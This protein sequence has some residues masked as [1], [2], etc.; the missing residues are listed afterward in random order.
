MLLVTSWRGSHR[1]DL[2]NFFATH[3]RKTG[4]EKISKAMQKVKYIM[5]VIGEK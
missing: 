3:S 4:S 5:R 1:H 2:C